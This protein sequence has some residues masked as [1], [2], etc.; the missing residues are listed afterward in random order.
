VLGPLPAIYR[1]IVAVCAVL[2][3]IGL[4]AWLAYTLP[5]PLQAPA[6]A[7]IGAG[8]GVVAVLGILHDFH[9]RHPPAHHVRARAYRRH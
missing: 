5:I 4:G 2:A 8:I 3:F 9:H 7:G 6:G 1:V